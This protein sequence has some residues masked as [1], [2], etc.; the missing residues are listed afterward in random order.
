[1]R[2]KRERCLEVESLESM[3]LLSGMAG[4]AYKAAVPNPLHLVGS[5]HGTVTMMKSTGSTSVNASGNLTPIGKVT[6]T[7]KLPPA[8]VTATTGNLNLTTKQGKLS[9]GLTITGLSGTYTITGGTKAY[10]GETG[11]GS[12]AATL[13]SAKSGKFSATFS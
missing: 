3:T 7:G 4:A 9:L 5:I 13:I 10:A 2:K 11:S 1:M 6:F 8:S 12:F